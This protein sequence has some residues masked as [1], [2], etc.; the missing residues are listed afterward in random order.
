MEADGPMGAAL[1]SRQDD[2]MHGL[3]LVTVGGSRPAR[4]RTMRHWQVGTS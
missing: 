3:P 1:F 2:K 4:G